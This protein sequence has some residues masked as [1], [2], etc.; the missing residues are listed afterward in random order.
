MARN[1]R[2][3]PDQVEIQDVDEYDLIPSTFRG[4][5]VSPGTLAFGRDMLLPIPVLANYNLLRERRQAIIDDNVRRVNLRRIFRDYQP[6]DRVLLK[7]FDPSK[8]Q[9]R[10]EGPFV[11]HQ[12]HVNGT[13]TINRANNVLER[14]N[15]RRLRP[16]HQR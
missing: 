2:G 15:I 7:V 11:I 14:I 8:L 6:G 12:V 10:A 9:E 13:V 4:L 1:Q 16:Y 3:A 5:G